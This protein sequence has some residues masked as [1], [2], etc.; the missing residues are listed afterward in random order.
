MSQEKL[1]ECKL[2]FYFL[3]KGHANKV[4]KC[5]LSDPEKENY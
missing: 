5:L 3:K 1:E 4:Y 2:R